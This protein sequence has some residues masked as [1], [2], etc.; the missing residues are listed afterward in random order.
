MQFV[1]NGEYTPP[2]TLKKDYE[3]F[4]E[5]ELTLRKGHF[6]G[7]M[8]RDELIEKINSLEDEYS[9]RVFWEDVYGFND[10]DSLHSFLEGIGMST[11]NLEHELEHGNEAKGRG[12]SIFYCARMIVDDDII[13]YYPFTYVIGNLGREDF[14]AIAE[15]PDDPS[16]HDSRFLEDIS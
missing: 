4:F 16:P 2:R 9:D 10:Y 6:K 15:A 5:K 12:Y 11:E 8:S 7:E 13:G 14:L 3:E 1:G